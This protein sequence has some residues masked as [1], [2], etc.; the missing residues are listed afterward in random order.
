MVCPQSRIPVI[1]LRRPQSSTSSPCLRAQACG[2]AAST[3]PYT[4]RNGSGPP[5]FR[6]LVV[7]PCPSKRAPTGTS[8]PSTAPRL[9]L[10]RGAM[11][12]NRMRSIVACRKLPALG[13]PEGNL[14]INAAHVVYA[15]VD[16]AHTLEFECAG[17]NRI[18]LLCDSA[19]RR[20]Y[21]IRISDLSRHVELE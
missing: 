14:E 21:D 20:W 1:R 4:R 8:L 13:L 10:E 12:V 15:P 16:F 2:N 6:H 19:Q 3:G 18:R 9:Y 7:G 11:H 17:N 5:Q